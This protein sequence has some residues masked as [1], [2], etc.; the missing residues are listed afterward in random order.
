MNIGAVALFA[1]KP[2]CFQHSGVPVPA[3][4]VVGFEPANA[5]ESP[6]MPGDVVFR[7]GL[8]EVSCPDGPVLVARAF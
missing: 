7:H 8:D 6:I 4:L 5:H 1:R 3:G 2:E